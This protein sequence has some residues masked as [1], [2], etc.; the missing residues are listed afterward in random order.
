[1]RGREV[2]LA[3]MVTHATSPMMLNMSASQNVRAEFHD[4]MKAQCFAI[5]Q[6]AFIEGACRGVELVRDELRK[7][8]N[9]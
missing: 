6:Q 3:E 5:A 1:M 7:S 8:K 4:R 2:N 9:R